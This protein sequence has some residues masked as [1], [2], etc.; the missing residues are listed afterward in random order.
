M[1]GSLPALILALAVS[2]ETQMD[3][4]AT[5]SIEQT[6]LSKEQAAM[7]RWRH[8]DPLGW[9]EISSDEVTYIDP[10][11]TEPVR[12]LGAY[13][14]YLEQFAGKISY[15]RSEFID[16]RVAVYGEL[17]VLTY[18]YISTVLGEEGEVVSQTPWNSTEV[19][20]SLAGAWKIIHTHWS[21]IDEKPPDKL[22]MRLP[23]DLGKTEYEG[24]LAELLSLE[25][26]AME[27]WR[28]GDPWGF[29]ELSADEVTYFDTG[30][31]RR[32]DGLEALRAEYEMIEGR[33]RYDV[34]EFVDP[35]V[36][37]HGDAA[38][39]SYRYFS[40]VLEPDG[41]IASRT[42]W[43]CTEVFVRREGEWKIVHTHWSFILGE[44]R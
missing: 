37:V 1:A 41:S 19:Y 10:G 12:G 36:Q 7:E 43:N 30:T 6:I 28:K 42:P 27:R 3:P 4:G 22:Q 14:D 40:T 23:V 21:F 9:A 16:P 31:P 25:A 17:A 44:R 33:V 29:T 38:V 32:I 35:H 11:L 2:L 13:R 20:A 39:L 26:A 18:N 8:G 5:Q 24:I 15:D 34:M